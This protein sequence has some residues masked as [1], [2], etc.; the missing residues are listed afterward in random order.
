MAKPKH[1]EHGETVLNR[2]WV[3][4]TRKSKKIRWSDCNTSESPNLACQTCCF[5]RKI[6]RGGMKSR[7]TIVFFNSKFKPRIT[8]QI[9]HGTGSPGPAGPSDGQTRGLTQRFERATF[10]PTWIRPLPHNKSS[11]Y[12]VK[13]RAYSL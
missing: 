5:A 9:V 11:A 10:S 7:F 1:I 12:S 6:S 2:I 13:R 3:K 4:Y 8:L